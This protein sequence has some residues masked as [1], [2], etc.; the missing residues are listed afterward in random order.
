M[1]WGIPLYPDGWVNPKD[2]PAWT[3]LNGILGM[4]KKNVAYENVNRNQ[5]GLSSNCNW[6][7]FH[8]KIL[9]GM[10]LI[11]CKMIIL[12]FGVR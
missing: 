1:K 7:I 8:H 9:M 6:M 10:G 2:H 12:K 11:S 3:E 4:V 5:Q